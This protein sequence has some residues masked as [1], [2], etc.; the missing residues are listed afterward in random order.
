MIHANNP[1][2]MTFVDSLEDFGPKRKKLMETSWAYFFRHHILPGIPV[3]KVYKHFSQFGRPTKELYASLGTL[4]IQQTFD[5]TDHDML[6]QLAFNTQWHYA[7][8]ITKADDNSAYMCP[9]T[10]YNIRYVIIEHDLW[11]SLF[12]SITGSLVEKFNIDTDKQRL[13][14]THI[15]SNMRSLGRIGVLSQTIHKFLTNLKRKNR[16]LFDRLPEELVTKYFKKKQLSSFSMIKPS[17][18]A[19]TLKFLSE[20]LL[21][22]VQRF[23]GNSLTERMKSFALLKRV[24]D[25]QCELAP[26]NKLGKTRVTAE[27]KASKKIASYS[28][29]N[30]SD[31]DAGYDSHKGK[32]YQV[33]VMETWSDDKS[34]NKPNLITHVTVEPA[35]K[36][37]SK[38]VIPAIEDAEEKGV[39]PKEL[40]ADSLYGN[41]EN[42]QNA[43]QLGVTLIS[44]T[45][46]G[47]TKSEKLH[48][49]DFRLNGKSR[50]AFCPNNKQPISQRVKNETILTKFN[51]SHCDVC[52][53]RAKCPVK[54]SKKN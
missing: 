20:D 43:K 1:L 49:T 23:S 22:L 50:I 52:S 11:D 29:Q 25:E 32:G 9:K 14:S 31:P 28:L 33:Q 34:D 24:L 54:D 26:Q 47:A 46:D 36:H 16:S 4:I 39:K 6:Y 44:P 3:R 15:Q 17:E 13:D 21:D 37:D 27:P 30:P 38:A 18:S 40:L 53:L 41:D 2:Q 51:R 45:L 7:L 12:N 10:L 35:H 5:L 19:K 8:N 48:L 42:T